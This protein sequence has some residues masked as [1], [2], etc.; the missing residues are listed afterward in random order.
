MVSHKKMVIFHSFLYV[1][2]A[3]C[4]F[5]LLHGA[6]LFPQLEVLQLDGPGHAV[7]FFRPSWSSGFF[8]GDPRVIP[9]NGHRNSKFS[10]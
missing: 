6:E 9:L 10:H 8:A 4:S 5:H 3:S 1:Y 7:T 2:L